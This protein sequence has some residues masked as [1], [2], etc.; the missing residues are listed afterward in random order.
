MYESVL[1]RFF[2]SIKILFLTFGYF[3]DF[4]FLFICGL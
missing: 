1:S 3:A 2:V 4:L